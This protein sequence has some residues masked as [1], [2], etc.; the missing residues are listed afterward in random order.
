MLR[1]ARSLARLAVPASLVLAMSACPKPDETVTETP[2]DTSNA[3][4]EEASTPIQGFEVQ[5][6]QF[7]DIRVL[8]YQVPGFS[9]LPVQQKKLVYYLAQA[10]LSGRDIVW[11][12]HYRHNLLV[13]R[14]LEALVRKVGDDRADPQVLKLLEYT[15]RVWFS[16]GIH[17]HY[18]MKKIMPEF[19]AEQFATWMKAVDPAALPLAEGENPEQLVA[20][21]TPI[22]F[23]PKV[24]AK[25][26]E[27]DPKKDLIR[28]S[29][30]NFYE[31]VGQKEV[32]RF[33]KGKAKQKDAQPVSY[34]L[35]SKLVKEKGKLVERTWKVGGMYDPAIKEI[36]KWLKLASTV[37]ENEKQKDAIDKLVT[38][39]ETGELKAFDDYS[40]AWVADTDSRVDVVNGFIEVYGD[41]L[42]YKGTWEAIVSIKDLEASKRIAAIGAQAQWF[43]DNSPVPKPYKKASV[44]GI[45]AKVITVVVEAGDSAPSTPIGI[46][47]PNANWIRNEHGSKSVNL[48][49]IV[50]S[51]D[52]A[53]KTGG[54]LEEFAAS[55][56]EVERARKWSDVADTLHT[57]MHEVIGHASGQLKPGVGQPNDTLKNY[58]NT[59]EE[60]RADL[61]ALYYM[62]DPKLLEIGVMKDLETGKAS[63]DAYIRSAL[64]VQ[65]SRIELGEQLEESHMRNR[66]MIAKWAFEN[67]KADKVI[68]RVEKDGKT[69]FVVRDYDKLRA[70][71]GKLLAEVQRIKSEGDYAAGKKLV[72]TYGVKLDPA[73]HKQ[74]KERYAAL[75]I[76]PYAG[77][78]QPRLV[79]AMNGT[80]IID[81][82]I[83]Y[84]SDFTAQMFEYAEQYSHLPTVN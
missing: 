81:V 13:R 65:M 75:G 80:E 49:N 1:L 6:E 54:V 37:A 51:Y 28:A 5:T 73:L 76:A 66:Q 77:F 22:L 11:D 31:G 33:Y 18:S 21:L 36:V 45:S 14:T 20:K 62:L 55:P 52:V 15:K 67:G 10:A 7:A 78:I 56:E 38:Y 74:V 39:Y 64:L 32:E 70:L 68:E 60:A 4:R 9:E 69:Y 17:H 71:F 23:D 35:N 8:R 63:Y 46:N 41:P 58:G 34:G 3:P 24:D 27:L 57:D 59:L 72:E 82:K 29:A 19:T 40:I 2:T 53:K 48:G 50:H 26:V 47:L 16:N 83:E 30:T 79:P 43:E 84:P 44:V 42:G 12:Q 25:R 61:V